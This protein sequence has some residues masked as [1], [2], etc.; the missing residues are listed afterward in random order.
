MCLA[1]PS[2]PITALAAGPATSAALTADGRV[3]TCGCGAY[4]ATG[5]GDDTN[6]SLPR[7]VVWAPPPGS[8]GGGATP[9]RSPIVA[10]ALGG[11]HTLLVDAAGVLYTCGRALP[12]GHGGTAAVLSPTALPLPAPAGRAVVAVAAGRNHCLAVDDEGA[13][14]AWGA[15]YDGALGLGTKA[16]ARTP[17]RVPLPPAAPGGG[18]P[19]VVTAAAAGRDFS[20]L[21]TAAGRVLSAGCDDSGQLGV[22]RG[23][24]SRYVRSF[25]PLA[26]P[27]GTVTITAV[28]AGDGHGLALDADGGVW[29]WGAGADGS[30]GDGQRGSDAP[31]ARRVAGIAGRVVAVDAGGGHSAALTEG[32]VLYLWGRGRDGQ[33]GRADSGR[34]GAAA[35]GGGGVVLASAAA[36]ALT[37]VPLTGV[38]EVAA[39][40][41]GGDHTLALLRADA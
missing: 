23:H 16:D 21:L 1:H 19:P 18:P 39:V 34:E 40:A 7:E 22:G 35:G 4:G 6:L 13:V 30:L 31:L 29:A 17:T 41:L 9:A 25:G 2:S 38:G 27:I 14:Y 24:P 20:L 12:A 5:H 32:G 28:A 8:G 10:V 33:L 37:P 36:Y 3:Y 11:T 26:G 15:G